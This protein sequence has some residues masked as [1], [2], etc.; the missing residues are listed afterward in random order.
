M[1]IRQDTEHAQ[2]CLVA[3]RIPDAALDDIKR[4]E[5]IGKYLNIELF[6]NWRAY[7]TNTLSD[8]ITSVDARHTSK[9]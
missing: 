8:S 4:H 7:N 2:Y 9:W 1:E 3:K 5:N 6:L